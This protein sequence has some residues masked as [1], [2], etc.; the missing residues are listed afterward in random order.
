MSVMKGKRERGRGEGKCWSVCLVSVCSNV[1]R[2]GETDIG[3]RPKGSSLADYG[4][5]NNMPSQDVSSFFVT[6]TNT[7]R[8][9]LDVCVFLCGKKSTH[10]LFDGLSPPQGSLFTVDGRRTMRTQEIDHGPNN[11]ERMRKGRAKGWRKGVGCAPKKK[12]EKRNRKVYVRLYRKNTR[13]RRMD[14]RGGRHAFPISRAMA[15]G[16]AIT[17]IVKLAYYHHYYHRHH[18]HHL[19]EPVK[20]SARCFVR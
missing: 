17:I 14:E 6:G 18:R 8:A 16:K 3:E 5:T 9:P 15:R 2:W 11:E 10:T 7:A 12:K 19:V 20:S 4:H 13:A 1:M